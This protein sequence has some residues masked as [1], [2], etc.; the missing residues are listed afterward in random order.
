MSRARPHCHL[1]DEEPIDPGLP[2][3]DAHH[4]L[5]DRPNLRYLLDELKADLASGHNLVATVFV[6]A[7]AMYRDRGP[8]AMRPVG[9]TEFAKG[10]ADACAADPECQ[11]QVCAG[12]VCHADLML[13]ESVEEVLGEHV[14]A[15]G[16]L[17][18]G[19]LRGVRHIAAW[20]ADQEMLNG[21]Y[22]TTPN[23]L[24]DARFRAGFAKLA[25]YGLRYDAWLYYHQLYGLAALARSF[26]HIPIVVDHCGGILGIRAYAGRHAEVFAE[27]SKAL[28]QLAACDNVAI[29]LG[30]LGMPISG[31]THSECGRRPDS[32][33]LCTAWRPW[34]ETCIEIFGTSRCMFESNYP[35]DR[36]SHTYGTGWNAM[37]RLAAG[38]TETERD[39]LF[40]RTA[41]R[42]YGL[43]MPGSGDIT[44]AG[45]SS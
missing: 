7:H 37:K 11:T 17:H 13:G 45:R 44:Q 12:I 41:A 21:A 14:R 3:V 5:Y 28:R 25:K 27:W 20:D 1:K 43:E 24:D 10:V 42:F 19:N 32:A 33:E 2:I 23:M 4:H 6:Q 22:P 35:A 34:I 30:G 38:A 40:W 36:Q 31:L 29:K 8:E 18:R 16:G 26:P 15:A 39:N 9:E